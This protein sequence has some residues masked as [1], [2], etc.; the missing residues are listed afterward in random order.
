MKWSQWP[1]RLK[2]TTVLLLLTLVGGSAGG[3]VYWWISRPLAAPKT[4]ESGLTVM[5]SR[6]FKEEPAYR[7]L[8]YL[9]KVNDLFKSLPQEEQDRIEQAARADFNLDTRLRAMRARLQNAETLDKALRL[10]RAHGEERL[11]LLDEEI[12][13][14]DAARANAPARSPTTR[15]SVVRP[16]ASQPTMDQMRTRAR[17]WEENRIQTGNPQEMPLL[18]E[19]WRAVWNRRQER[20][21]GTVG[22]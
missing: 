8:E 17:S 18:Q 13:R 21:A 19:Y 2:V 10:A 15:P 6:K 12:A 22:P 7:Q 20:E 1:V 11:R 14:Q 4:V 9:R 3:A 16:A 5:D